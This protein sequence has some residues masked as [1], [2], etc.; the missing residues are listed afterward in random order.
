MRVLVGVLELVVLGHVLEEVGL[1]RRRACVQVGLAVA[2]A[3]EVDLLGAR[4]VS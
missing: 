2:W 3:P 1:E 4:V